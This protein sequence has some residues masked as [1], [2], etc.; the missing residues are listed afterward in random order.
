LRCYAQVVWVNAQADGRF[1]IGC[2]IHDYN[3]KVSDP[4]VN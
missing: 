4:Q 3:F 2:R 1:G